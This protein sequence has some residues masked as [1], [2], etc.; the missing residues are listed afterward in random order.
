MAF[1]SWTAFRDHLL[2]QMADGDVT[3][4]QVDYAGK[5]FT[6]RTHDEFMRLLNYVEHR[7]ALEDEGLPLRTYAGEGGRGA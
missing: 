1:T 5:S 7:V 2:D 3:F 4:G 6:Y